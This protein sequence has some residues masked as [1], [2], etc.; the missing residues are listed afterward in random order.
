MKSQSVTIIVDEIE[1]SGKISVENNIIY[2]DFGISK[3]I[4]YFNDIKVI[5]KNENNSINI[6]LSDNSMITLKF[7]EYL[8]LYKMANEYI[9]EKKNKKGKKCPECGEINDN[10]VKECT[11][12]GYPLNN[13]KTI[14]KRLVVLLTIISLIFI[15]FFLLKNIEYKNRHFNNQKLNSENYNKIDNSESDIPTIKKIVEKYN[16]SEMYIYNLNNV[17]SERSDFN[18]LKI[19]EDNVY[20]MEYYDHQYDYD[21]DNNIFL[22]GTII[23]CLI[24]KAKSPDSSITNFLEEFKNDHLKVNKKLEVGIL[25]KDGSIIN[26]SFSDEYIYA[27]KNASIG[28]VGN[29]YYYI[30]SKSKDAENELITELGNKMINYANKNKNILREHNKKRKIEFEEEL[31][32]FSSNN[33]KNN[34]KKEKDYKGYI[35]FFKCGDKYKIGYSKDVDKRIKQLDYRPYKIE[36]ITKSILLEKAY[37][38]EQ[39]LH[40]KYKNNKV[41]GEWYDFNENQVKEIKKYINNLEEE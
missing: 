23:R 37:L 34:I 36:F 41:I 39:D 2:L 29:F 6:V 14:I 11:N 9:D 31:K 25:T 32:G 8:V 15:V 40:N 28:N 35:Y 38:I 1:S 33:Y 20:F 19:I 5:D 17:Y 10:D 18:S 16:N 27:V 13:K 7:K 24:I 4:I 30:A 26:P 22:E 3:Q 21:Y 12:C